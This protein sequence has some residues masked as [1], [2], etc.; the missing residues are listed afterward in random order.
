[1]LEEMAR[2]WWVLALRGGLAVLFGLLAWIWP[3]ITVLALAL[4]FGA[5]ALVD[6]AVALYHAFKGGVRGQSRSWLAL[7][8]A[9]G[10]VV[11]LLALFWPG[12]TAFALIVLIGAWAIA[13]GVT[14]IVAA[15]WMRRQIEGE[16]WH[17]LSGALSVLFGLALLVWPGAGGLALVWLIGVFSIAFGVALIA[18][19]FR[20]RSLRHGTGAARPGAQV[21]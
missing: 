5:Y 4:L 18:A 16:W 12:A 3:G 15:I 6:G 21:H 7:T 8:G 2:N 9:C 19:A 17:V 1:M 13:T 14:E 20:L 10:V 11:G